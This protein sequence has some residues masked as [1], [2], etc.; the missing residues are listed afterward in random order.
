LLFFATN[1]NDHAYVLNYWITRENWTQAVEALKFQTSPE[2]FYKSASA[3]LAHVPMD[4]VSIWI[5]QQKNLDPTK[6]TPALLHYNSAVTIPLNQN[7]AVRYLIYAIDQ[8]GNKHS[9]VHNALISI[10][11]SHSGST[12]Q[13]LLN[14]LKSQPTPGYYDVDFAL[15]LCLQFHRIESAVY[16]YSA[17]DLYE[18][19]VELSLENDDVDLAIQI[20]QVPEDDVART[21]KLWLSIVQKVLCQPDGMKRSSLPRRVVVH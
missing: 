5:Q 12:E 14:F 18:Q 15:R 7:Q 17:M 13:F 6:L 2:I 4:T 19:A 9:S 8:L 11:A 20:A 1:I 16:I 21:K 10:Y 3:L